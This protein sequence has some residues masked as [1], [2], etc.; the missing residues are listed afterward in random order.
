MLLFITF[1]IAI[2]SLILVLLIAEES[3]DIPNWLWLIAMLTGCAGLL[4]SVALSI[5]ILVGGLA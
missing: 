1:I 2:V 5:H 4:L 3:N